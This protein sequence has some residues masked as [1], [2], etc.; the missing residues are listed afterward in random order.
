[1]RGSLRLTPKLTLTFVVFAFLL[2]LIVGLLA[3]RS[4]R[5]SLEN[6]TFLGLLSTAIEKESALETWISEA[7]N[8]IVNL[9]ASPIMQERV[10]AIRSNSELVD[11][12]SIHNALIRELAPFIGKE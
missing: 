5:T 3:Y 4:G 12:N 7:Q 11:I 10:T 1:M 2:L 6:S 9:A 8:Q